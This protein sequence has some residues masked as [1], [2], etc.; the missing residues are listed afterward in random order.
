M[1]FFDNEYSNITSV[2]KLGV[3]C[4]YTPNGMTKEAWDDALIMFN[5][6]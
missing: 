3:K 5:L 6:L 2:Q 1:V 4:I